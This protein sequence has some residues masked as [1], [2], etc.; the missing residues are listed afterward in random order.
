MEIQK[1]TQNEI[2]KTLSEQQEQ[3]EGSQDV[4]RDEI[5]RLQ[6]KYE[7]LKQSVQGDN[8][9]EDMYEIVQKL[10]QNLDLYKKIVRDPIAFISTVPVG[11]SGKSEKKDLDREREIYKRGLK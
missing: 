1:Y 2:E 7:G 3:F 6:D 4:V 8:L 5:H 10:H 9:N 11:K